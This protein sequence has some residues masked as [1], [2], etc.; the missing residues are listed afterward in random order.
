MAGVKCPGVGLTT[1]RRPPKSSSKGGR[2]PVDYL[3]TAL[4]TLFVTLDPPGL[5]PVS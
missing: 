1:P 2:M 3:K 4:V 5:A